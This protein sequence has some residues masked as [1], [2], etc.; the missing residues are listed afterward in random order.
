M[1]TVCAFWGWESRWA[2]FAR[3]RGTGYN[4]ATKGLGACFV[5]ATAASLVAAFVTLWIRDDSAGLRCGGLECVA[6]ED[7]DEAYGTSGVS[8]EE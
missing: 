3:A 2:E 6:G 1:C 8:G 5:A 4:D 7:A